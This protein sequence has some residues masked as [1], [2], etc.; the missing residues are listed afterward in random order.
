MLLKQRS[1]S[2]MIVSGCSTLLNSFA[3]CGMLQKVHS[4]WL[5]QYPNTGFCVWQVV[6]NMHQ[7]G[8]AWRDAKPQNIICTAGHGSENPLVAVLDFGV[9]LPMK[10]GEQLSLG[11]FKP[12]YQIY[13]CKMTLNVSFGF[14]LCAHAMPL[15]SYK[16]C[17]CLQHTCHH[18]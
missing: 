1:S 5:K 12:A 6:A 7:R 2:H 17:M 13:S 8:I 15:S 16:I 10:I 3:W 9:S 18:P 11:K 4:T 14:M